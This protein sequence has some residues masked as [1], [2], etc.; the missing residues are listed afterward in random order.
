[1]RIMIQENERGFLFKNGRFVRMLEPGRHMTL[2]F[3]GHRVNVVE[4]GD[5]PFTDER[6]IATYGKD[7]N[8]QKSIVKVDVGDGQIALHY[9]DG[10][11][12]GV[13]EKGGYAYWNVFRKHAFQIT[14]TLD[15]TSLENVPLMAYSKD[16]NF[17][18]H[19]VK[20]DV[21]DGQIALHYV[22][23]RY[24]G[25]LEKG[26]Y[27]YWNTF[28]K[29][30]FKIVS[31]LDDTSLKDIPLMAYG[32]DENFQKH[33]VK[34][35]VA[36]GQIA[37]HYV[38]GR[39]CGVLEKGGYAYWNTFHKHTFRIADMLDDASSKDIPLP[40]LASLQNRLCTQVVVDDW[41]AVLLYI[42][43]A[44][45]RRL[46][47]GRHFFWQNGR[48]I[49]LVEYDMRTVQMEVLGQEILTLDKV[50][51]RV[52]FVCQYRVIDPIQLHNEF[53]D[54]Q[55]QLYVTLQLT[56]REIIGRLRLDEI[57]ELRNSIADKALDLLRE[58][59]DFPLE[60]QSAGVKDIILPGEIRDIMNT[61]LVAEKKA[62]ANVI[63]RREEVASTRSLLNTARLM[64]ENKTLYKLKELEYLEKICENVSSISVSSASGLLEQ[65]SSIMKV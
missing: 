9:V 46:P 22:D 16:E 39:Y 48:V 62:Q 56:L 64:D 14:D 12:S 28:H 55:K 30:T 57:L 15:N 52:N 5:Q 23:G 33:I 32:K 10:R 41:Q 3:F 44:F 36:D 25:V 19:I 18:K 51:L 13:L 17:Q 24:C 11:Y 7:E 1:M 2:P 26:G 42:D 20:V 31:M 45:V 63:T 35:D 61:V 34:V 49:S 47:S 29:H 60:F 4:V 6:L 37:L 54:Y 53:Q 50:G 21:A 27:A 38:D 58:K 40:I 43:G 8:F 65:L 59:K